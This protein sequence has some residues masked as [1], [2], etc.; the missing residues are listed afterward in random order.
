MSVIDPS[1]S[2]SD[3]RAL[4]EQSNAWPFE[5]AKA[6]VARLKKS[7]KDEVLFETGYGPSGLPHIGTFGEV[8]RTSMVR[9][10][11]R[12][13][14]EDKI[15]TRLLAF[16]DDMDGLRKVP[17]NV[18]NRAPLEA[19]LGKPLTKVPDPFGTHPSFGAHNNARLRAFLDHFGF[20]YE[21]ASSTDYYTSGRFDATLLRMLERIEKVMAI[22]LPSLRE[23]RAA[24][25]SP[26]LPICP[27]TGLVL[28]VPVTAHDAKA[29]TISYEDPDTKETVTVPVTGGRCKLQW[30]ADWAMRWVALGV[31]YEMAGKDLID[32]VKLSGAIA[33]ALGATPPEGFNYE[34]FL[35]EKGQKIS[36]SKGNGLTID[37]WLRYAS[38]ESLSLFMYREPKA[39]KRLYFDVIPRNVDDYQQFLDGFA[40]QDGKQQ[41]P[42]WHI[43]NGKPPKGDMPVTFQLLLTL[44]S[45]S[46]AENAETL[47]GFIGRYRPGVTPQTHP[48]L[49][50]MVGYAIN[51]YRDFVA[52]TKQFRVPTDGERAAL[53]NLRDAL[54]N[55]PANASAED[56]QNVVYEVGRR[57]PF[58]DQV[59]KGKDGRPG[60]TLDWFNMLY[61]VLLGQ[62]KGPRFGSFVAVYGVQN[63][64]NM[65]DGALARSS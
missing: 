39:A 9:H 1:A 57:E 52:P 47:W 29:G 61:Q 55:M 56:I 60:V 6:I 62:E 32:S 58:L 63:A 20:D 53:Q 44:V 28:Y 26:F 50:A 34:L 41:N 38:P 14:T 49:D 35:D 45:S 4:A 64:V 19:N 18:Q 7:P 23:E 48:K 40:K 27:R 65:I 12:V 31:D 15:K 2:P 51:Y 21:F 36:K 11:F 5:Q 22:M 13:L 59:K 16:S 3:L 43:H 8:A 46:N 37:E 24:S 17:D 10:A 30:K 33:R 42:V 25:Y 54:A